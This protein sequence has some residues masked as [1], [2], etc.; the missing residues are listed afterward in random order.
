MQDRTHGNDLNFLVDYIFS[1]FL[2]KERERE[3][4][5]VSIVPNICL[6]LSSLHPMKG[7][8]L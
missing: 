1:L 4:K 6:H 7:L 5:I 8:R 2:L 3:R